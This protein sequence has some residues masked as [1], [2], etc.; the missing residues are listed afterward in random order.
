MSPTETDSVLLIRYGMNHLDTVTLIPK[1]YD[2]LLSKMFLMEIFLLWSCRRLTG[3]NHLLHLVQQWQEHPCTV[4][5]LLLV[6]TLP[7][8]LTFQYNSCFF[9]D[10]FPSNV[11]LDDSVFLFICLVAC[12]YFFSLLSLCFPVGIRHPW[13][14][15]RLFV[16]DS[17]LRL[18]VEL[19]EVRECHVYV[20]VFS[21]ACFTSHHLEHFCLFLHVRPNDQ[22][23]A[24]LAFFSLPHFHH[25]PFVSQGHLGL[26]APPGWLDDNFCSGL[27][28]WAGLRFRRL[29][30][31]PCLICHI[32]MD[33]GWG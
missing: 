1:V 5:C 27:A 24:W 29:T 7:F 3:W 28:V 2:N 18:S 32:W 13:L 17:F 23:W 12:Y 20:V 31:H 6:W 19:S 21:A 14:A 25:C 33:A 8:L 10:C 4:C 22:V 26:L 9:Q 11:C 16:H 30:S 15:P